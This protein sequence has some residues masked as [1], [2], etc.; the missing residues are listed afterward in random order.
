MAAQFGVNITVDAEAARPISIQSITPIGIA[1]TAEGIEDGLYYYGSVSAAK[2]VL[3]D[4][5]AVGSILKAIRA[6]DEQVVETPV[7]FS[8]FT[9]G[10]NEGET[11]TACRNA[12]EAF[13]RAKAEF[14]YIPN[15]LIAPEYSHFSAVAST[16]QAEAERLNAV[17]VIDLAAT[18]E[19]AAITEAGS[20]GS[21]RVLLLNPKVKVWSEDTNDYV[22][23]PLSAYYAGLRA[24]TDGEWEYGWSDSVSNRV[25]NGTFGTERPIEFI[26]GETCEADRLRSAHIGTIIRQEGWRLWGEETTDQDAVW[27]DLTRVRI[28]DRISEACQKG[29]LFA[30]DKRADQLLYAKLSVEELL[31]ALKGANVLV[32]YD[33]SWNA[34]QNTQANIT[35][36]KFYLDIR[37]QN[38]PIVKTLQLNF[39][40]SDAWSE[41]LLANLG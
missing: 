16:L 28:F 12:I 31:R 41:T 23:E 33:V 22:Y 27:Q 19:T 29:V 9:V 21:R 39:I 38:N 32:G 5:D 34:A 15:I 35:A 8:V 1:G 3:E 36:G 6:I 26:L 10:A 37:M 40:Y 17:G 2:K 18:S 4:A 20:F 24:K 13:R 14:D 7:I 11:T 30:I 25:V